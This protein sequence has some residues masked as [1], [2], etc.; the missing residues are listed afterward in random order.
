MPLLLLF[1]FLLAPLAL[2]WL[3]YSRI[4]AYL[5]NHGCEVHSKRRLPKLSRWYSYGRQVELPCFEVCYRA[6]NRKVYLELLQYANFKGI[7]SLERRFM[8]VAS[9]TST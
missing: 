4:N 1:V 9:I 8:A 7:K 2:I 6:K 5:E 3:R